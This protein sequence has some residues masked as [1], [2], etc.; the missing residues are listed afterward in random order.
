M[1][2]PVL[3]TLLNLSGPSFLVFYGA[4][5]VAVLMV[6]RVLKRHVLPGPAPSA[7]AHRLSAYELASLAGGPARAVTTALARLTHLDV[8]APAEGGPGFTVRQPLPAH[9]HELERAL[10]Q[11][12]EQSTVVPPTLLTLSRLDER[13]VQPF[14]QL[15]AKLVERGW[16]VSP[17]APRTHWVRM[18]VAVLWLALIALGVAKL[19]IGVVRDRPVGILVVLL[20][21]AF[22]SAWFSWRHIPRL[23]PRGDA[24]LGD[25]SRRNAALRTTLTRGSQSGHNV[26]HEDLLLG[27]ALF[28]TVVLVD[29]PLAWMEPVRPASNSSG[30][31]GSSSGSCGGGSSCGGGGGGCGGCGGG[32]CS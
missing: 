11:E 16:L 13:H 17:T 20:G 15:N 27:V 7:G 5:F 10:Y 23:T 25:L 31:G 1:N 2:L 4:A 26:S 8:L 12:I 30:D 24:M 14:E 3:S 21:I 6:V 28:G 29:S 19:G 18:G 22:V 9:A 32:G